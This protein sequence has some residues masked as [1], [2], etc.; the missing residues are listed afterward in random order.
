MLG[1]RPL[2]PEASKEVGFVRTSVHLAGVEHLANFD[3]A[4]EQFLAGGLDIGDDQV[5]ALGG[6]GCRG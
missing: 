2:T 5:E 1:I 4:T 6:A 3:A